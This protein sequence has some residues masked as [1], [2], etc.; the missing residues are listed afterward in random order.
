MPVKFCLKKIARLKNAHK[1]EI[2]LF[3]KIDPFLEQMTIKLK[4]MKCEFVDQ[5]Y[6]N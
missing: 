3:P 4:A 2:G 1:F 6:K 5:N